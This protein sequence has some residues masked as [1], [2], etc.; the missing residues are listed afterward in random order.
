M[1]LNTPIDWL[2]EGDPWVVYRTRLD[3]LEQT[4]D[5]PQVIFARSAMLAHP[6]VAGLVSEL[7]NWPGQVLSSHKSASQPFHKLTFLADLGLKTTDPGMANII[8][9]I[10]AHQ[11]DEGPFQ[12]PMNIPEHYGGTGVDTGAWALCDAPLIVYSLVKMGLGDDQKVIRAV[13]HLVGLI[14]ENGWPCAVSRELGK[15]RGPGRKDDPCP[16]CRSGYA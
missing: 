11:S 5:D 10:L 14:C 8:D 2:L 13:E 7:A 4:R 1:I 12:L 9:Q 16:L 15:F 3:L 6:Q